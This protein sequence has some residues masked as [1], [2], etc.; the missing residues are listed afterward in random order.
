MANRGEW[1]TSV[2]S[3]V[4]R[5]LARY[6]ADLAVEDTYLCQL[7]RG[8]LIQCIDKQGDTRP[9]PTALAPLVTRIQERGA[10]LMIDDVATDS[11]VAEATAN[12]LSGAFL[13]VGAVND[14]GV[15][16]GMVLAHGHTPRSWSN[17]DLERAGDT[18]Q[19]LT[20]V[21][22]LDELRRHAELRIDA[23]VRAREL[24]LQM[25]TISAR[26][27]AAGSLPE[28]SRILVTETPSLLG[29]DWAVVGMRDP[30]TDWRVY[31]APDHIEAC[32]AVF[33]GSGAPGDVL[34]EHVAERNETRREITEASVPTWPTIRDQLGE[35]N[36]F[37]LLGAPLA[38]NDGL[39]MVL[40]C[41]FSTMDMD[42]QTDYVFE[43]MLGD[44]RRAVERTAAAQSQ[45]RAASTLQRSLLPPR[46]PDLDGFTIGR[47]YKSA[48]DHTRVGGDW[49]DIVQID[50]ATTGFVVGDVAGH[51][52]R[53]AA[54]M[55]QM[56]HV[57]ASQLR[58]RRRPAGALAATDR[59][60]ADLAENIMATAV[61]IVV[62]QSTRSAHVALAGHP[63]PVLVTNTSAS[64]LEATPGPPIGFGFGGYRDTTYPLQGGDT[65]VAY[66]DGV[67]E[68]R[69]G[70]LSVLLD[71]FVTSVG[72]YAGSTVDEVI[73]FLDERSAQGEL[74]DDVAA[75]VVRLS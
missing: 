4:G 48:A 12:D 25:H 38:T 36:S 30:E 6:A 8:V 42:L 17:R 21:L 73:R 43:E 72:T 60:F 45:I 27:A 37:E 18:A 59:Y 52:I 31:A 70:N 71:E 15:L 22:M 50:E 16:I 7:R 49:Y 53:S 39:S 46:V 23:E 24:R 58:D 32:A 10:L 19:A 14:A 68:N 3:G 65:L 11:V 1:P 64:F 33:G 26:S 63:P 47:L 20:S 34:L 5:L 61:V 66:T 13:G 29:A 44:V 62:D 54:L 40:L 35:S 56:R 69:T 75:L 2:R 51:D 55:G 67:V 28:L 74:V 57:L 9:V 41:G